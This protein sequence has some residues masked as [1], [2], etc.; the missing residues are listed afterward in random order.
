MTG[1][2]HLSDKALQQYADV[3]RLLLEMITEHPDIQQVNYFF[4]LFIYNNLIKFIG[5]QQRIGRFHSKA[6]GER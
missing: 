6:M 4:P 1:D 5:C 3:H 2:V